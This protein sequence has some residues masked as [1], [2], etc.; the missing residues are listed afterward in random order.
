ML[1]HPR[2]SSRYDPTDRSRTSK[3]HKTDLLYIQN[4]RARPPTLATL[5]FNRPATVY[6][7]V[8]VRFE[9]GPHYLPGW[10]SVGYARLVYPSS[11]EVRFGV[12]Q[13]DTVLF[14]Y[15]AYVFSRR[16]DKQLVVP[17]EQFIWRSAPR[18]VQTIRTHMRIAERDGAPSRM[19]GFFRGKR[20]ESNTQCP[21]E[22]HGKWRARH[23]DTR[24]PQVR[25]RTFATWHPA[26][27]PC[28]WCTYGHEHG[29]SP[30]HLMGYKPTFGYTALKNNMEDESHPGF[31]NFVFK[32]GNYWVLFGIHAHTS[33]LRRVTERFHTAILV[34]VHQSGEK[35]FEMTHKADYGFLAAKGK[36]GLIPVRDVDKRIERNQDRFHGT[37]RFRTINVVDKNRLDHRYKYQKFRSLILRGVYEDWDTSMQ[38]VKAEPFG[39]IEV[40]FKTPI[41]GI[42]SLAKYYEKVSLRKGAHRNVGIFRGI[43]LHIVAGARHCKFDNRRGSFRGGVFY[44]TV[45]GRRL[46]SGPGPNAVRQFVKPGFELRIRGDY[47]VTEQ[48]LGLFEDGGLGHWY[49]H[50]FGINPWKN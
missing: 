10:S 12:Y 9:N 24:D 46:L 19:R 37:R 13:R 35:V 49:D 7:F 29:S 23:S 5:Y 14:P 43:N 41:T 34:I 17:T 25:D 2:H 16:A 20:V 45:D 36:H 40:D 31:K 44:T 39:E 3:Y 33:S 30:E 18:L 15:V 11:G 42:K 48:G 28:F 38:C 1:Y 6:L 32:E 27:D 4:G 26:W 47:E 50:G 21:K 22:L 8:G